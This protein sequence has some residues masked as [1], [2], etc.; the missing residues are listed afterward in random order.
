MMGFNYT[1][2]RAIGGRASPSRNGL[3]RIPLLILAVWLV[4]QSCG[5]IVINREIRR[6]IYSPIVDNY[7]RVHDYKGAKVMQAG[8]DYDLFCV[9][10]Y[11]WE[12]I[13]VRYEQ[14]DDTG[15]YKVGYSVKSHRK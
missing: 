7:D 12:R 9:R 13:K 15:I 8:E 2:G 10:H 3:V 4:S 5:T 6:T 1:G 11:K 14:S